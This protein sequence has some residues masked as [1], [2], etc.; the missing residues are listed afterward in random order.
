M[1]LSRNAGLETAIIK[2]CTLEVH[3]YITRASVN[4]VNP[5]VMITE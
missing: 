1:H 5:D 4:L 2:D 3:N